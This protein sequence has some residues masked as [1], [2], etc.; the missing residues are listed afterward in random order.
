MLDGYNTFDS[1]WAKAIITT[2][3]AINRI[4]L[5]RILRKSSY[6]LLIGRKPNISYF[7]VFGCECYILW[8]G[9]RLSKFQSHCDVG[10]FTWLFFK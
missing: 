2:C 10:F 5:H 1:F 9:V 8:K 3:H 4:Y 7:H 6:E